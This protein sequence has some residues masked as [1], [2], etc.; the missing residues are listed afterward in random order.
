MIEKEEVIK[1]M[2]DAMKI[3]FDQW[4]LIQQICFAIGNIAFI[5]DF[6]SSV[7]AE[8]GIEWVLKAM[9]LHHAHPLMLTEAIFFLKNF[10]FGERGRRVIIDNDGVTPILDA[11]ENNLANTELVELAINVLFDLSFSGGVEI[12]MRDQRGI[13]LIIK[14]ALMY[15]TEQVIFKQALAAISRFYSLSNPEQKLLIIRAG[16]VDAL[17]ELETPE[18]QRSIRRILLRFSQDL[19]T[20]ETKPDRLVPSLMEFSARAVNLYSIKVPPLC[21]PPEVNRY[22]D[23]G[24]RCTLCGKG[25]FDTFYEKLTY[26]IYPG[27]EGLVLPK[28]FVTCSYQ[29]FEQVEI[30]KDL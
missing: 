15:K 21:L 29:C 24:K 2:I 17:L 25:Y 14:A 20:Y 30:K 6:E 16:A 3:H 27:G 19:L 4:E 11:L 26:R 1:V 8:K 12:I 5:G 23:T 10:A 9:R 22:L 7:I 18:N 13:S 28:I